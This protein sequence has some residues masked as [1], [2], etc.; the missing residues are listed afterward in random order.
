MA[1]E[2]EKKKLCS[3]DKLF[4]SRCGAESVQLTL[5][6]IRFLAEEI[7][8]K[9]YISP[10][11]EERPQALLVGEMQSINTLATIILDYLDQADATTTE[12]ISAI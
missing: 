11:N 8:E 1:D 6:K 9:A 4:L 7:T 12:I 10:I 3:Q 5:T 2:N